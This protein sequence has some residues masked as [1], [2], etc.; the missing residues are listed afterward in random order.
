MSLTVSVAAESRDLT[1][2]ATVKSML[3]IT[4]SASDT[5]LSFIISSASE[6]IVDYCNRE[7]VRETVIET[8]PGNNR[9]TLLLERTPVVS[10]SEVSFDDAVFAT[11][12]DS[13][14]VIESANAGILFRESAFVGYNMQSPGIALGPSPQRGK[15]VWSITYVSGFT[16]PSFASPDDAPNLPKS[17]EQACIETVV[18]WFKA[19]DRDPE[20][21]SEKIADI[22]SVTYKGLSATKGQAVG[23]NGNKIPATAL[24]MLEKWVRV[25]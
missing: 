6:A 18:A 14:I 25:V 2:L 22:Y 3:G 8:L 17:I 5:I 24:G 23:V 4:D 13:G 11:V 15:N 12:A 1:T 19:R 9:T 20:V 21:S 10:I 7:F 16:L